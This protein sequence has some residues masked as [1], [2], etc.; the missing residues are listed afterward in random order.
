M[1]VRKGISAAAVF[2]VDYT[3]ARRP[4]VT[5]AS[6]APCPICRRPNDQ[7]SDQVRRESER[8]AEKQ[9]VP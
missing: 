3:R 4:M 2:E 1:N 8:N 9:S 6:P 7:P 5:P